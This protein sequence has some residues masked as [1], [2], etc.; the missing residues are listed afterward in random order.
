MVTGEFRFVR[1]H[2]IGAC[3]VSRPPHSLHEWL[4]VDG[5]VRLLVPGASLADPRPLSISYVPHAATM[6]RFEDCFEQQHEI[7]VHG[8]PVD[9]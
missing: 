4:S 7:E 8:D 2:D 3:S 6:I 5:S 9:R 1:S